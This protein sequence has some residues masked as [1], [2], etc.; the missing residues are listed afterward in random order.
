MILAAGQDFTPVA[1]VEKFAEDVQAAGIDAE[2]HVYPQ[3]PHSYFDRTFGEHEDACADS[4]R[5]ILDFVDR[6]RHIAPKEGL[7]YLTL[8][9]RVGPSPNKGVAMFERRWSPVGAGQNLGGAILPRC[10]D[11][12]TQ[13]LALEAATDVV[14]QTASDQEESLCRTSSLRHRI[15]PGA[16]AFKYR[17]R[18]DGRWA[19]GYEIADVRRRGAVGP[20][21]R[22]RRRS[23]HAVLPGLFPRTELRPEP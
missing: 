11:P 8:V 1:D 21:Y 23:D 9:A 3:A 5:R 6:L 15:S 18:F 19:R 22:I 20:A 16:R 17:T 2:L 7:T 4:W 14:R 10:D 13:A 12:P